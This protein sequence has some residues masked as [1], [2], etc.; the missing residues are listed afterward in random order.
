M[1]D[2][3][4]AGA[5]PPASLLAQNTSPIQDDMV[6]RLRK[7]YSRDLIIEKVDD[8]KAAS[9]S[10]PSSTNAPK[11]PAVTGEKAVYV[12]NPDPV[13]TTVVADIELRHQ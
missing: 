7:T 6:Q 13:K 5:G 10:E 1:S 3:K 9:S 11:R 2:R 8:S 12:V 4:P